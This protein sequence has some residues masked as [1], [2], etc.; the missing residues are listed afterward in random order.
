MKTTRKHDKEIENIVSGF[1]DKYFYRKIADKNGIEITRW[2]DRE[3]QLSGIDVTVGNLNFDEKCKCY[4]CMNSILQYPSF[5]VSLDLR[6]GKRLDGWFVNQNMKTDYYSFLGL[7]ASV[8]N[9]KDLVSES[10]LE[11]IDVLWVKKT[12]VVELIKNIDS[13]TIDQ[14]K[15]LASNLILEAKNDMDAGI[16]QQKYRRK[17]P[18]GK[19]WLTYS[20][21]LFE[22]PVNLVVPRETLENLPHSKHFEV[23]RNKVI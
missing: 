18:S 14:I 16:F 20:P 4:G 11:K 8:D 10:Q 22:K 9:P 23:S 12:D 6:F 2:T 13:L 15:S 21:K 17:F 3:H 1:L 7:F 5:E 19:F